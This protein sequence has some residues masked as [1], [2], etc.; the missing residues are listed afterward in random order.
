MILIE[1]CRLFL[2]EKLY[3][4]ISDYSSLKVFG[5]TCLVLCLQ[6]EDGK[7]SSLSSICNFIVYGDAQKI[8]HYYEAQSRKLYG[9]IMLYLLRTFIFTHFP[10]IMIL[11][12]VRNSPVLIIFVLM[13]MLLVIVIL[14]IAHDRYYC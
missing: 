10:L 5:S 3:D 1:S 7:L 9:F 13:V 8:S 2:F 6:V 14:I 11:L 4:I 12:I